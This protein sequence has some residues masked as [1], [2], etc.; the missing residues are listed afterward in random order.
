MI[1]R[2]NTVIITINNDIGILQFPTKLG[3]LIHCINHSTEMYRLAVLVFEHIC[4]SL[5][6]LAK[7]HFNRNATRSIKFTADNFSI[8]FGLSQ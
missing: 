7:L 3:Q 5:T 2:R 4:K 8:N 6:I 1:F